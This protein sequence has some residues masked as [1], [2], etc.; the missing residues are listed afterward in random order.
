MDSIDISAALSSAIVTL[1]EESI[2]NLGIIITSFVIPNGFDNG[3]VWGFS[4][5][6]MFE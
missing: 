4:N 3:P 6:L 2:R 5:M 1:L